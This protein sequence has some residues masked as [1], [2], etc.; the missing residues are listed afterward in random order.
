VTSYGAEA[1]H[2]IANLLHTYTAIA[3]RKDVAAAA[4]LLGAT[5]VSFPTG[6]FTDRAGAA[7]FYTALWASP[8]PHRHD[9]TNLVVLPGE[10]PGTWTAHAHYTRWVFEPDPALHTLGEYSLVVAD[11]D[12]RALDLTVTRTWTRPEH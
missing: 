8:V 11:G 9:V 1:R 5:R 2:E 10:A 3:D 12:W 4:D 7:E 6:G